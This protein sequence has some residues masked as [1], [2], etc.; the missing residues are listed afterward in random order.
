MAF[1][2][3]VT[4]SICSELQQLAGA[5][6]DKIF[7]PNK[8]NIILGCYNNGFNYAINICTDPQ[9]YRIHLTTH[10]RANPQVAPNFCM[11][12][13]KHLIGLHIKNIFTK[14]LERII[15][16]EF[17]GFNDI[18]DLISKKLVVELMGKHCNIILLSEQNII[19]DCLRHINSMDTNYNR[20]PHSRYIFPTSSKYDFLDIFNF[21][22]F[23]NKLV[24]I[25]NVNILPK[26]FSNNFNGISISFIKAIMDKFSISSLNDANLEKIYNYIKEVIYNIYNFNLQFELIDNKKDFFL[27]PVTKNSNNFELNFFVDAFYY[28]KETSEEL[29]TYKNAILKLVLSKLK[30]YKKR[31]VNI[32]EK[33]KECDDMDKYQLYGELITANLYK[34]DNK[35]VDYIELENYYDDYKL[36]KILL[37]KK[38]SPSQNAKRFFKKY[39]KLKN[40]LQI[41]T[42]QKEDTLKELDYIESIVYELENCTSIEEL[43]I[44]YDEISENVVFKDFINKQNNKK[45]PKIKKSKL[46]KNKNVQF[47]PIKYTINGY[48]FLVGKNNKENDYLTLKYAQKTDIWFHTKDIHGSHCIL[49]IKPGDN[50]DSDLLIKCAQIAAFHSKAQNSSN[51]PVDICEVKYVKK[52]NGAKPGMVVY[53]NNQTINVQP[54]I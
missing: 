44:I 4:K 30:K 36:I 11:I 26:E 10:P 33:L 1:D 3:I 23:K 48:T 5:R 8:N 38:Y 45:Q 17:E 39:N 21:N 47:N 12:L 32:N 53:T 25:T 46:T 7:Q 22:D 37:D 29:K 49:T 41:V 6:L 2:G 31:L 28:K 40:A 14:G 20:L 52:P 15:I 42:I 19:I 35:N 51:V 34:I 54:S 24:G 16:I 18:D 27:V 13:R 9:N 43:S 50:P